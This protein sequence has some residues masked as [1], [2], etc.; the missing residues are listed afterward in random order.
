MAI[1][2]T[3]QPQSPVSI[4]IKKAWK[5]FME[6]GTEDRSKKLVPKRYLA[7]KDSG[8]GAGEDK[9]QPESLLEAVAATCCKMDDVQPSFSDVENQNSH[10]V[11]EEGVSNEAASDDNNPDTSTILKGNPFKVLASTNTVPS[12]A[13]P[14]SSEEKPS[15]NAHQ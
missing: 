3:L 1:H 6:A 8:G 15:E 9:N 7:T 14:E 4:S 2:F 5:R 11:E 13:P 10:V 12:E